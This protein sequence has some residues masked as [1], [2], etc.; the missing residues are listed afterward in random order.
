MEAFEAIG[1]DV[2]HRHDRHRRRDDRPRFLGACKIG[3]R[4]NKVKADLV[5]HSAGRA[6]A[7]DRLNI[8]A[9]NVA[10]EKGRLQLNGYLQ[11]VSNPAV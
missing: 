9:A 2:A 7:L 3:Q 8:A 4:A 11:S 1:V 5:V 6:P 10:L